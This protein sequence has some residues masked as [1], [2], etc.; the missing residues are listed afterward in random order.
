MTKPARGARFPSEG[1]A[2]SV[3]TLKHDKRAMVWHYTYTELNMRFHNI[4]FNLKTKI[5]NAKQT[6]G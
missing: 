3:T 2:V 6:F 1:A 5:N 4:G